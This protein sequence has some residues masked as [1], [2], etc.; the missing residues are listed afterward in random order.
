MM[1]L[2]DLFKDDDEDYKLAEAAFQ[3]FLENGD[4]STGQGI[5][6]E[7]IGGGS[8]ALPPIYISVAGPSGVGKTTIIATIMR[9]TTKALPAPFKVSP[10]AQ[11]DQARIAKF[12]RELQAAISSGDFTRNSQAL[13]GTQG[14]ATYKYRIEYKDIVQQPF[15]IMDVP[16]GWLRAENRQQDQWARYEE[17]L[18]KSIALW[19]PVE[20][21]LLMEAK[22]PPEK[23]KM[24][25]FLMTTDVRDVVE[26]W[27]KYRAMDEHSDEPAVLC[28]APMKCET[29]FS[30]AASEEI[31]EKFFDA[32]MRQYAEIVET[33]KESCPRC[34][35]FYA[36]VES[37]GCVK[38]E[39]MDWCLTSVDEPPA[40]F[41]E[42]L[43]PYHQEIA[44]VEGLTSAVYRYGAQQIRTALQAQ[45]RDTYQSHNEV[46]K[47]RSAK[48]EEYNNRNVFTKFADAFG[49][50][51][52]K[53]AE[54]RQLKQEWKRQKEELKQLSKELGLLSDVLTG[55]ASRSDQSRYFK[56]LYG[57]EAIADFTQVVKLDPNNPIV[58]HN[59]GNAFYEKGDY[60]EAIADFTQV[61]KLDPNNPVA[62]N[63][64]GFIYAEIGDYDKAIA[65]YTQSLKLD[66]N[67]AAAY[68]NRGFIYA[69]IG[70][71]G[72]AITDYGQAIKLDP[73]NAEAYNRLGK[74]W[75]ESGD[76][77]V[78][79]ANFNRAE[80]IDPNDAD[81]CNNRGRAYY[82]R[83]DYDRAIVNFTHAVKLDSTNATVYLNRGFAYAIK[84]DYDSAIVDY[85]QSI[86]LDPNN[87]FVY[88]YRGFAYYAK[89]DYGSAITDYTQA[90]KLDSNN[91]V[92]YNNRGNAYADKGDYDQAIADFTQALKLDPD[93]AIIYFNRGDAYYRKGDY[94]TAIA[95]FDRAVTLDP[96]NAQYK[97]SLKIA[98]RRGK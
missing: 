98:K 18:Q 53:V 68:N 63:N 88:N 60:D 5:S 61:V 58:Y 38:L 69:E 70:D 84:G 17:H 3:E 83:G 96:K 47:E 1:G 80:E 81:I 78:A 2:F 4:K 34:E 93:N 36:P 14:I 11:A 67:N 39:K 40:I 91:M 49:G 52:M 54:L 82:G 13:A 90:I 48:Q 22:T 16:G 29:Y 19:V 50:A 56:K 7:C 43:A 75:S 21:P 25:R 32:F 59:R 62:Y 79:I 87:A 46:H 30:K 8:T 86:K 9:D 65:D 28:I 64:R 51:Q 37:I 55:L 76:Y 45:L 20:S 24:A 95:D 92:I 57:N 15:S 35:I 26:Q 27:A 23:K 77:D 94:D 12:N 85:T 10:A 31:P 6:N 71:R 44:G 41:Y 89:S 97:K 42:V 73:N 74:V 66:P 33:A 72:N